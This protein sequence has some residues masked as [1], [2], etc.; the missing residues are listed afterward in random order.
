MSV[1]SSASVPLPR[2]AAWLLRVAVLR[3]G[4]L[5]RRPPRPPLRL[6]RPEH[7]ARLAPHRRRARRARPPRPGAWPGVALGA[8]LAN[9]ATPIPLAAAAAIAA[10]NTLE[11]VLA[12]SLLMRAAGRRP[13]L[14]AM[15]TVRAL[16]LVAA[17]LGAHR[18]RD[19]RRHRPDDG[20]RPAQRRRRRGGR[21][22]GGPATCS[23]RW[24]RATAPGLGLVPPSTASARGP[25]EVVLLCLGTV[26]AAEFGLGHLLP[27]P[28]FRLWTTSTC[29]FPSSSG[30]RSASAAAGRRS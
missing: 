16:V 28:L 13:R 20:R 9:A 23:A 15:G 7:L 24:C 12:A 22:S 4:V 18:E 29:C 30:Q 6:D 3:R 14:D 19:H 26:I 5:R 1:L 10:G 27:V 25:L 17:P 11:A 2:P 21:A 8:F